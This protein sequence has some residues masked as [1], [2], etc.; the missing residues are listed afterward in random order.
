MISNYVDAHCHLDL[1]Q[2]IQYAVNKEDD[3]PIK[4]ITVTNAPYAYQPNQSLFEGTKNIRVGLGFHPELAA[5]YESQFDQFVQN[6]SAARYIGEVG[7]DGS[8]RFKNTYL[9][10]RS[11]FEK[12]ILAITRTDAKIITVHS[13][14]AVSETI[15]LLYK[16]LKGTNNKIIL[17]W[18]S[19]DKASLLKAVNYGYYFSINHKMLGSEKGLQIIRQIPENQLLT[20]TDAPFTFDK[21]IKSRLES[22]RHTIKGLSAIW[23]YEEEAVKS[24]I[25]SNFKNLLIP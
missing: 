18:Y 21:T 5:Q 4:T 20:E 15:D 2:G 3:L 14:N 7:L 6:L 25:Y 12:I 23:N 8:T 22:L 13:R 9:V 1:F 10:Q 17:H 16:N 11:I 24:K 19:G